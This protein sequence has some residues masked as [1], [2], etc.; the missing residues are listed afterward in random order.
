MRFASLL[1]SAFI[2]GAGSVHALEF[3]VISWSGA[4][5]N[6]RYENA[7]RSV[8]LLAD[9]G[10][11]SESYSLRTGGILELYREVGPDGHKTRE[12]VAKL[13]PP[14]RLEQA[15][16]V[17][18]PLDAAGSGYTGLWIDDSPTARPVNHLAFRNLSS[19]AVALKVGGDEFNLAPQGGRQLVFDPT[20]R[21]L[22][23][24]LAAQA[25]AG[26]T[27]VATQPQ[28][29]RQGYRIL[30]LLRD[31]RINQED[32]SFRP[33]DLVTIFDR[34]PVASLTGDGR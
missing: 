25:G 32:G 17:L 21:S 31:G 34:M 20:K 29:V 26:W 5:T 14:E 15:I 23:L 9:E 22:P 7:G 24:K 18:A 1:L 33:V 6:L 3:R 8:A 2:L 27:L 19:H 30:V 13:S 28:T 10:V 12:T 11:L 4:L 16:L